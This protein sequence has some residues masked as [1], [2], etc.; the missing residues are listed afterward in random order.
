MKEL[1]SEAKLLVG[2]DISRKMLLKAKKRTQ[3]RGN[4]HFVLADSDFLPFRDGTFSHTLSFTLLQNVPNPSSTVKE[5]ARTTQLDSVAVISILKKAHRIEKL[6][7]LLRAV[8]LRL[9]SV[10][11]GDKD[12]VTVFRK[13]G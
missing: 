1:S 4:S 9:V 8:G 5:I 11:D 13:S 6:N 7:H 10:L 2:V 12:A 3:A